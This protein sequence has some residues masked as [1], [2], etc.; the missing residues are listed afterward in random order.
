MAS[1]DIVQ[2]QVFFAEGS[3][4][5]KSSGPEAKRLR[6]EGESMMLVVEAPL[7][8]FLVEVTVKLIRKINSRRM[9]SCM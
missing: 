5:L 7:C 3:C 8:C 6:F 4:E 9:Q 2:V 1:D